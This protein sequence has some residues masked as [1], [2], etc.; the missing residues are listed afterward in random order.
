[1]YAYLRLDGTPYYIG[2][3]KGAR[4]YDAHKTKAGPSIRPH[5]LRRI[6][7]VARG[8]TDVGSLAMERRL[9]R[10]YGRKDIGTGILRNRTDGGEGGHGLSQTPEHK[11]KIGRANKGRIKT[12]EEIAKTV[13][14][15]TG[16][17]KSK[18]HVA[19]V[20]AANTGRKHTD[21]TRAR[22]AAAQT[23]FKHMPVV[24]VT[25][26]VEFANM[27]A[28]GEWLMSIEAQTISRYGRTIRSAI[29]SGSTAFGFH[30]HIGCV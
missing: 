26:G 1:M 20:V 5:D 24:N 19:K 7:I 15:N 12:P 25:L 21:E 11:S 29:K 14:A 27:R 2:K 10:W 9:I 23:G 17:P 8:L 30:W 18:E 13:A 3:G 22:M 28:V 16:R 4:A 6:V